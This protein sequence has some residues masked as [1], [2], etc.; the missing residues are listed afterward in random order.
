[1]ILCIICSLTI[2]GCLYKQIMQTTETISSFACVKFLRKQNTTL[3]E[4][5]IH[6]NS[7]HS[8]IQT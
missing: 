1:M 6:I 7:L 5:K 3:C 2:I 4:L 8:L